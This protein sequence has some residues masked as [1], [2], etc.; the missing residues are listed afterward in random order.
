M[1]PWLR[2]VLIDCLLYEAAREQYKK[3]LRRKWGPELPVRNCSHCSL[4]GALHRVTQLHNTQL[5]ASCPN[6]K[7]LTYGVL[8]C[9]AALGVSV[10]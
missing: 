10:L 8:A 6:L 1:N 4:H 2:L 5:H 3:Y 9:Q 7:A